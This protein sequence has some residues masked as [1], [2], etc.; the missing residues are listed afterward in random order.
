MPPTNRNAATPKQAS[1]KSSIGRSGSASCWAARV[2]LV[3]HMFGLPSH[4]R[5]TT[6][7]SQEC[8]GGDGHTSCWQCT[9]RVLVFVTNRERQTKQATC[10]FFLIDLMF[11]RNPISI[12]RTCPE[13]TPHFSPGKRR[14]K[15]EVI[16]GRIPS[17]RRS[18]EFSVC[19]RQSGTVLIISFS[20]DLSPLPF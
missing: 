16:L 17:P 8:A 5:L 15:C 7:L 20:A 14:Q 9:S 10:A 12:L 4:S 11:S 18:G 2:A 6:V 1:T 3:S 19:S 13:I